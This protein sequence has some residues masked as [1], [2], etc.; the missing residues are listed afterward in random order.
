M[1]VKT[2]KTITILK[3]IKITAAKTAF[4][5]VVIF[6]FISMFG[7]SVKAQDTTAPAAITNLTASNPTASSITL[8]WTAPGDDGTIGTAAAYD[9]RYSTTNITEANWNSATQVTGETFP[10]TAGSAETH[11]VTGLTSETTYYFAVKTTDEVSNESGLSN[12]GMDTTAETSGNIYFY[13]DAEDQVVGETLPHASGNPANFCQT[14]CGG[15]G[16]KGTVQSRGG[17]PQGNQYF[18][19][20]IAESQDNAYTEIA[21]N[22]TP[23]GGWGFDVPFGTTL[24]MAF[25][26]KYVLTGDSEYIWY[27]DR[28]VCGPSNPLGNCSDKGVELWGYDSNDTRVLRTNVIMGQPYSQSS[29]PDN[30]PYKWNM[31]HAIFYG[32]N[33]ETVWGNNRSGYQPYVSSYQADYG[34]WYAVVMKI[35][36]SNTGTGEA[37]LWVNGTLIEEYNDIN[38]ILPGTV[39]DIEI[40]RIK[41][42]GT[43]AQPRYEVQQHKRQFDALILTDSWQNIVDG[44]YLSDPEAGVTIPPIGSNPDNFTLQQNYPNPFN[45][46]TTIK[47]SMAKPCDVQIKIYNQLGQEVYTLVNERKVAGEYN[48][49]WNGRDAKGNELAS[50]IYYY[51]LTAGKRVDTKK[52]LYLQ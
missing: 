4:F 28:D 39:G 26:Q 21:S 22:T 18:E 45:P 48:V 35:T 16:E 46:S 8:T 33:P 44:G 12:V 51:R 29:F 20:V 50:G 15:L 9:I 36:L 10:Q 24:Y 40:R 14:P 3:P 17:A 34:K 7:E 47:Y 11:T 13:Y 1:D 2:M 27:W 19:W 49:R 23:E 37:A 30:D 41:M 25:Y 38:T 31:R 43:I 6:L 52:M 42:N 32:D 5:A